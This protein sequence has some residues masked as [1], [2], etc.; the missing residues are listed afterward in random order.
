MPSSA[1]RESTHPE[2]I[3]GDRS[4]VHPELESERDEHR[5]VAVFCCQRGDD[6]SAAEGKERELQYDKRRHQYE[7]IRRDASFYPVED[8]EDQQKDVLYREHYETGDYGRDR[9]DHAREVDLAHDAG[10]RDESVR[11]LGEAG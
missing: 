6:Y 10:V 1:G 4:R 5:E 2:H 7:E 8:H 9:H 11:G 3:V